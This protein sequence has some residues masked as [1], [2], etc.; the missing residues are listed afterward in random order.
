MKGA[1]YWNDRA[2]QNIIAGERSVLDYEAQMRSIYLEA[3][4]SIRKELDAFYNRYAK[5]NKI[6]YAD[7]RRQLN[8]MEFISFKEAVRE[9]SRKAKELG[10]SQDYSNYLEKL[11]ARVYVSRL[12]ELQ[13]NIRYQIEQLSAYQTQALPELMG[14]NYIAGYYNGYYNFMQ[15]VEV[16]VSFTSVSTQD[17]D[18]FVKTNWAGRNYS[19]SIWADKQKLIQTIDTVLPKSFSRGFNANKLGD[20]ISKIM[21][22]SQNRGRALAR[23]EINYICNQST[24]QMYKAVGCVWYQYLATLDMRTSDICR[25]L[26]SLKFKVAEAKV[27]VNYPP[28]HTNCRSTTIPYFEDEQDIDRIAKDEYGKNISV[29]KSMTQE[30]WIKKY[31]PSDQQE[32]LLKFFDKFYR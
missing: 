28:M 17:I 26:D 22:V 24:L 21:G 32:K 25:D 4:R 19:S 3:L 23:T 9:W 30:E 11:S 7:A 29:P 10:L 27:N 13:A 15:G 31:A 1:A 14:T 18:T 8:R 6:A 2:E 5:E 12:E 16:G 20:E